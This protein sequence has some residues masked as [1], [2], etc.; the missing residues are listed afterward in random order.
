MKKLITKINTSNRFFED[1]QTKL[2]FL[3][4]EIRKFTTEYRHSTLNSPFAT[5]VSEFFKHITH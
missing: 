2:E 5:G 4:Y 3:K 1:A